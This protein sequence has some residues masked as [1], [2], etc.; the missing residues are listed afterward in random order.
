M[1]SPAN[2]NAR[3]DR[4]RRPRR[5]GRAARELVA[6]A[7]GRAIPLKVSAPFHCALMAPRPAP[8][9]PSSAR[10]RFGRRVSRRRELRR[11]AERDPARVAELLVR[12][13]TG[14]V[15]WDETIER[16]AAEGVTHA[17]EIGPGKVLAGLV[18]RIAKGIKVLSVGE[19]RRSSASRLSSRKP[20]STVEG[21]RAPV[22]KRRG[23]R[24]STTRA[25]GEAC[26]TRRQGGDRHGRLARH[27]PRSGGGAR[28]AG[29]DR[30]RHLRQGRG[31]GARG[32]RA[33][34]AR[35]GKA[36]VV[37]FDV[38]DMKAVDAAVD[39]CSSGSAGSTCSSPTPASR[40]TG[41]C[42]ASRRRTS[43][44]SSR[45]RQGPSPARAPRAGDDARPGGR[46]IF[47]SSVVGEMGNAGRRSTPRPRRRCS[48]PRARRARVRLARHHGERGG[49]R[50]HRHRH[51]HRD[52]RRAEGEADEVIPLGRTGPPE[53]IA[54][55]SVPCSDEAGY[56]TG[57][58]LRVNGGMYM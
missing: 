25:L 7:K 18:K 2:F 35:G 14:A 50:V 38:A 9:P 40:S 54:A 47:L 3:A 27:R 28:G 1:I 44:V 8:S 4:H 49:A 58:T 36:E 24:L 5:S 11:R 42:S 21:R 53:E 39:E 17:L 45:Q 13:V 15:R 51:D 32:R 12:Q 33:I 20:S 41:C 23:G 22:Y 43:S 26:S 48:A 37:G 31:G 29:R 6:T 57:Q 55:A 34:A 19:R 10:S 16:M 56:I 52:H 30:G 46:I